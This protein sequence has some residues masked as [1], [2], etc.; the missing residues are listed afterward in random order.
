MSVQSFRRVLHRLLF[1]F[2]RRDSNEH[3]LAHLM[4]Y[5]PFVSRR[6]PN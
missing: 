1:A 4:Q 5:H 2:P 3:A 6:A